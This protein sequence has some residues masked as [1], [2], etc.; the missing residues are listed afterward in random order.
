MKHRAL[1]LARY[2]G[3]GLLVLI[4]V[5]VVQVALVRFI[6]PPFTAYM[7]WD[8][9]GSG[10]EFDLILDWKPARDISPN[11]ARAVLASEDQRFF[12]HFGFDWKEMRNAIEDAQSGKGLRGAST[13]TMQT[14]RN[15]FLW[16]GRSY[17]R[18]VLEAWYTLLLELFVPKARILEIYLNV[19]QFGPDMYGVPAAVEHYYNIPASR[20]G[21]Y[22]AACLAAVLPNPERRS[23]LKKTTYM[24]KQVRFITR[25]MR[26]IKLEGWD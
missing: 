2:I 7:L 17:I 8:Y 14:A 15:L 21:P 23:P 3:F 24:R 20:I 9:F 11:M 19:A 1:K 16:S 10:P 22:H 5:S 18:K 25:Q 12:E 6:N 13:I 4:G 26:M